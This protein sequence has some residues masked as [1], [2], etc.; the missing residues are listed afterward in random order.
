MYNLT[1]RS[2]VLGATG[3]IAV[4]KAVDLASKLTQ[5]GASVEVL[6]T[7]EAA[8]FVSPITF[9]GVTGRRPYWDMWDANS[10]LAEPHISV[11]RA[12]DLMVIAPATATTI[13]RVA[14]GLAEDMVSLTALATRAPIVVCPAMD[15][16]MYEHAAIQEHVETL[17]RRGVHFIGPEEG[18]LASGQV[19]TGR[20]SEVEKILGGIRYVLGQR[21]DLTGKKIVVSA[22]PTHEPIDPV[23]FVG[24]RSSGKMGFA[25]A[26]AARDRGARTTLVT[27]PVSLA[28]PYGVESVH[29]ETA[30]QMRDAVLEQV[31][32]ADG[33][34][35]AAAVADYQPPE[36]L[37]QKIK[38]KDRDGLD[39]S[40]VRTPDILAEVGAR[41]GLIKVAFAAESHDVVGYA[42][43][44]IAS[45]GVDLIAANDI[46][47][48]GAGFGTE[49][50]RVTIIDRSGAE[51]ELPLLSKYDVAW[52]ILDRV[53]ALLGRPT[54]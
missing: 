37:G 26:E 7:P 23:R 52:R 47:A 32:D 28:D 43:Q 16:Q 24:N 31:A 34:V 27:G 18:R 35:M 51:E 9:Q 48:A 21:G 33:L 14:I 11:A 6:L 46:T 10:D 2:I 42:R 4:Y 5:C 22:G 39:L 1:D 53:V 3:S 36:A 49:T 54:T 40:L 45:K 38:R 30:S 8:R 29:V 13:A 50:N 15:S 41:P 19:G 44:K 17:R 25:L 12:A 20:F